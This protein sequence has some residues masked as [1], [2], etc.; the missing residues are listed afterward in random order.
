V[1]TIKGLNIQKNHNRF[2]VFLP[3]SGGMVAQATT[4]DAA[5]QW[6]HNPQIFQLP[7]DQHWFFT[8]ADGEKLLFRIERA[9]AIAQHI[10]KQERKENTRD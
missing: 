3:E 4:L 6:C 10:L 7:S 8:R 9:R 5:V 1:I 2:Q